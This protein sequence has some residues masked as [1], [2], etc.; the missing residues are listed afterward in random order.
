MS[1]ASRF[2]RPSKFRHVFAETTK[3]EVRLLVLGA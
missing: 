2:V 1:N 3:P